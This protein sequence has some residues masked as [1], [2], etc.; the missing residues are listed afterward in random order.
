[1]NY[2]TKV[3]WTQHLLAT[4]LVIAGTSIVYGWFSLIN[5]FFPNQTLLLCASTSAVCFA[6]YFFIRPLV[7]RKRIA[8]CPV[9]AQE[10]ATFKQV[11]DD[12]ILICDQCGYQEETEFTR[13]S[14]DI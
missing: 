6:V 9:C 11:N 14:D 10:S 5:L 4:F 1:M 2:A 12:A 13:V 8:Q 3:V 7:M